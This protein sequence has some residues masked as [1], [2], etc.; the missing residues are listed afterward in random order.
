[1]SASYESVMA[2]RNYR[3]RKH[4]RPRGAALVAQCQDLLNAR[5]LHVRM[6]EYLVGCREVSERC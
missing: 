1:M 2:S 3:L 6:E 5:F 4:L